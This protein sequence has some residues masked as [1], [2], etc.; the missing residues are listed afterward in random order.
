MFTCN[1]SNRFLRRILGGLMITV[2]VV[3]GSLT[4]AVTNVQSFM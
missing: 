3:I 2:T 1:D 4:Q